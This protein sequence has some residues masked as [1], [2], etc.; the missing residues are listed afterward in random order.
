MLIDNLFASALNILTFYTI[1]FPTRY[2]MWLN[3]ASNQVYLLL[4]NLMAALFVLYVCALTKLRRLQRSIL[5]IVGVVVS[6]EAILLFT[7]ERTHLIIYYDEALVYRHGSMQPILYVL[8]LGLVAAGETIFVL[9]RKNFNAYQM[10]AITGYI[11]IIFG[12][13]IFQIIFPRLVIG[14]LGCALVLFFL[15][16][17]F[18]N[19]ANYTYKDTRCFNR[20]AFNETIENYS[21]NR[22]PF[23]I[24]VIG[25][26]DLDYL[27]HYIG[28]Q[29]ADLLTGRIAER[30]EA[31]FHRIAYHLADD[32]YAL[33]CADAGSDQ[34]VLKEIDRCF[35][36]P[37]HMDWSET[38]IRISTR[39]I[40]GGYVAADIAHLEESISYLMDNPDD[41]TDAVKSI[42][43]AIA[44]KERHDQLVHILNRATARDE[45]EVF[46]QP[47][48]E[49][50]TG[51]YATAE[52]LIRLRDDTLG[53]ISPEEF[54]PVAEEQGKIIVIGE[55][56]FRRVCEF[57]QQTDLDALGVRYIEI[58]LSPLQCAQ[59]DL[60]ETLLKALS[61]HGI[62]PERINLEITETVKMDA[63]TERIMHE[64]MELLKEAGITFSIDDFGSGFAATDYLF[65]LPVSIV[66][67]DKSILWNAMKNEGARIVMLSTIRMVKELGKR[68]VVEGIETE[69][70]ASLLTENGCDYMQG[71]LFSKPVPQGEYVTFLERNQ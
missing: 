23:T 18:E 52:A 37:F 13:V 31:C 5:A 7:S 49:V 33:V 21:S 11:A 62:A 48:R 9:H 17:A 40:P 51:K 67:I 6:L 60:A 14:N 39:V 1:S 8:A 46:Y 12:C 28:E 61:D 64:N 24:Y 58:N 65:K 47:I 44:K 30:L 20:R 66:K 3:Y 50:T 54:I 26:Q 36:E 29:G 63:D 41:G 56:V 15:Y 25:I 19:P 53:Y 59:P 16:N 2:P 68:V 42:Q 45:F 69:E 70:M 43:A 55:I 27:R 4:Y 57:M 10:T 34:D 35:R 32:I 38:R 71:Y 22:Q